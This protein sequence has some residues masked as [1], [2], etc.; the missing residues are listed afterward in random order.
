MHEVI[1]RVKARG[2]RIYGVTVIPRHISQ[3]GAG[4]PGWTAEASKVR[5]DV[6]I[7]IR[8]KAPFDAVIDFDA[9]VRDPA[10]SDRIHAPF[11]CDDIHLSPRGYYEA[12]RS[13]GL[14]LFDPRSEL[15][16]GRDVSG[17][18]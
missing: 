6:N 13:V 3:P 17:A 4:N 1:L 12:A 18:R 7:W 5:R 16:R 15:R 11:N 10:D 8:T 14:D 2:L 9:A